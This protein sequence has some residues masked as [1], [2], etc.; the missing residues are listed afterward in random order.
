MENRNIYKMD[1]VLI[2]VSYLMLLPAAYFA[3]PW[4]RTIQDATDLSLFVQS[5]PTLLG[6]KL[7]MVLSYTVGAVS[8]QIVG[9]M[10]R[11]KEKQSL[12]IL[13]AMGYSGKTTIDQLANTCGM[14]ASRVRSLVKKLAKI[15]SV[16]IT[17]E[18]EKVVQGSRKRTAYERPEYKVQ[19]PSDSP[20]KF[21]SVG[22]QTTETL[23]MKVNGKDI[24]NKEMPLEVQGIMKDS[25]LNLIQKIKKIQ[26]FTQAHPEMNTEGME[27]LK[28]IHTMVSGDNKI[29]N[30]GKAVEG[31][32]AEGTRKKFKT[33]LFVILIMSPLWPIAII[34]AITYAVKQKK[35]FIPE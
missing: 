19:N 28:K 33:I 18:G 4:L 15:P 2:I 21:S 8:S 24:N 11:F 16:N 32:E 26:E 27:S 25:S 35:N 14:S 29:E 1:D 34:Y 10:I 31:K 9:R 20:E 23:S 22:E 30:M 6:S 12:K 17:L 13:D 5:A 7:T 3:W